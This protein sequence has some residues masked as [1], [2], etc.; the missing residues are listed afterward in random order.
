MPAGDEVSPHP[1]CAAQIL[2][3]D[4]TFRMSLLQEEVLGT[5]EGIRGMKQRISTLGLAALTMLLLTSCNPDSG[6]AYFEVVYPSGYVRTS[7][8]WDELT[9]VEG[10][11][12]QLRAEKAED[13]DKNYEY[14]LQFLDEAGALLYEL[15]GV[16][17]TTMRGETAGNGAV[18]VCSEWWDTI[19]HNGYLNGYLSRS[20]ILLVDMA[21]GE[22]LFQAETGENELYLTSEGTLCYFYKVGKSEQ[23]SACICCR[24]IQDWEAEQTVYTFDYAVEPD[25]AAYNDSMVKARFVLGD[26]QIRVAWESTDRVINSNGKYEAVFSENAA[27]EIPVS[28][29]PVKVMG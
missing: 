23:E 3:A 22:V 29:D 14:D 28:S 18:W 4:Y 20:V 26:D 6:S 9:P 2:S 13:Y 17:Q 16:G 10:T 1:I 21:D 8:T 5:G 15:P 12:Y 25:V 7:T 11:G 27:Y 19:H 24:D